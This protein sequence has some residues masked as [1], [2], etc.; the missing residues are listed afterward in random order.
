MYRPSQQFNTRLMLILVSSLTKLAAR[1][2]PLA[3]RVV[4]CLAKL[5]RYKPYFHPSVIERTHHCLAL[6]KHSSIAASLLDGTHS[7]E[8]L[9]HHIDPMSSL[10]F[11]LQPIVAISDSPV[12]SYKIHSFM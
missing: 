5:L 10:P 4:L 7:K 8:P 12:K 2:H 6:L 11:L 9:T 1:W 3:S